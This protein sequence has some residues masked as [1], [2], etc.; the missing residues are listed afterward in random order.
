MAPQTNQI[1]IKFSKKFI[2]HY[3]KAD[4]RIRHHVD[5]RIRIFEKNPQESLLR[6]HS[7]R[8]TW[9]GYRSINITADWR[10]IYKEIFES[11]KDLL[12]YFVALGTHKKLYGK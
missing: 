8:D 7:L 1:K 2:E 10:A 4:V 9:K 3:K 6:N 11:K 12:A 5:E